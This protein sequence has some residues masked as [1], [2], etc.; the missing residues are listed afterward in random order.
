MTGR[1]KGKGDCFEVGA[2]NVPPQPGMREIPRPAG[3]ERGFGMTLLNEA[4]ATLSAANC[5]SNF[6]SR[7]N[8]DVCT[9]LVAVIF[10]LLDMRLASGSEWRAR[11]KCD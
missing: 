10:S 6:S 9:A 7:E 8:F 1:G 4:H 3:K 11:K 2:A 5:E